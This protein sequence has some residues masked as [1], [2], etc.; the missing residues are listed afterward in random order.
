M[1]LLT[2]LN[3]TKIHHLYAFI[4]H[5]LNTFTDH[6]PDTVSQSE[7]SDWVALQWLSRIAPISHVCI[8]GSLFLIINHSYRNIPGTT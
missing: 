2:V 7:Q 8:F 6:Y 4:A 1:V 3:P 5:F